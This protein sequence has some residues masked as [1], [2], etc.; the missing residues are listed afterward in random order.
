MATIAIERSIYFSTFLGDAGEIRVGA[1]QLTFWRA[2]K[3]LER[4]HGLRS[5]D[6]S[7]TNPCGDDEGHEN[8]A[9][10]SGHDASA[11][12]WLSILEHCATSTI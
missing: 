9:D 11:L 2:R 6:N 8:S 3:A 5:A 1:F 7:A 4:R 10:C 12:C